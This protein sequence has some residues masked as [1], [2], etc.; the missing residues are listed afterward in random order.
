M[1]EK[2]MKKMLLI[3]LS[4]SF[5][6]AHIICSEKPKQ[7]NLN[8]V[9]RVR[10]VLSVA[11][12]II[13]TGYELIDTGYSSKNYASKECGM[14][15]YPHAEIWYN[16]M[17]EKYPV[18]NLH[19]S[20]F[21]QDNQ[22]L[23]TSNRIFAHPGALQAIDRI[24][25][26]KMSNATTNEED[27]KVL[28]MAEFILLHEAGHIKN[29]DFGA[30]TLGYEMFKINI[31]N[32]ILAL[33]SPE[34]HLGIVASGLVDETDPMKK[35]FKRE[36]RADKFACD[37]AQDADVL[38]GGLDFFNYLTINNLGEGGYVCLHSKVRAQK[39]LDEMK[40]RR[41]A[42]NTCPVLK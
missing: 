34:S 9:M 25:S 32:A 15:K 41:I 11:A 4:I 38:Q 27:N 7:N 1:K 18:A 29:N 26:E 21:C 8:V 5:V 24:Y 12:L 31:I 30:V 3:L 22:W 33:G 19:K 2:D 16:R 36:T 28:N 37:H 13:G 40:R 10:K 35:C 20:E 14:D 6:D 42:E 39:V 17:N 23:S